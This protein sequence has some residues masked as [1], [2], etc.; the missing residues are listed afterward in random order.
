MVTSLSIT[1]FTLFITL[2]TAVI[3]K[4][5]C[6]EEVAP[7]KFEYS[8]VVA[9]ARRYDLKT[10]SPYSIS[11]FFRMMT[12]FIFQQEHDQEFTFSISFL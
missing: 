12:I 10:Q 3:T 1:P 9:K 7:W 4:E 5:D 2:T 6:V 11:S 8:A